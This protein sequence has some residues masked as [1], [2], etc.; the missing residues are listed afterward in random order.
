MAGTAAGKEVSLTAAGNLTHIA[1]YTGM[2][3]DLQGIGVTAATLP[4]INY[5]DMT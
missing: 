1:G 3:W 2:T 5:V 4:I